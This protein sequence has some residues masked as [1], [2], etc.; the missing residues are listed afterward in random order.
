MTGP[1]RL[2]DDE[3][4]EAIGQ[5]LVVAICAF[6]AAAIIAVSWWIS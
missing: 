1:C 5:V 4:E 3:Q 6:G 2:T